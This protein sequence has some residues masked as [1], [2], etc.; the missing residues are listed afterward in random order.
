MELF[1]DEKSEC[2]SPVV[3]CDVKNCAYHD[4]KNACAANK[5]HVGPAHAISSNDTACASFKP[6]GL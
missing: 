5:I 4:G 2:P 6:S 1:K 3:Y